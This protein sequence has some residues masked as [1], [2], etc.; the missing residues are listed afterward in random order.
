MGESGDQDLTLINFYNIPMK[1]ESVSYFS[2]IETEAAFGRLPR[3]H[4]NSAFKPKSEFCVV[5]ENVYF[6]KP[7]F[8]KFN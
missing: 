7:L 6:L 1:L 8:Q 2:G 5:V 3:E 4:N